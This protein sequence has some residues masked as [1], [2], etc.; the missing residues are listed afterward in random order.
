MCN[1]QV[2]SDRTVL[3]SRQTFC[4]QLTFAGFLAQNLSFIDSAITYIVGHFLMIHHNFNYR[5]LFWENLVREALL[6]WQHSGSYR[7]V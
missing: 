1:Q 3:K 6:S 7:Q 4:S 2:I 5:I